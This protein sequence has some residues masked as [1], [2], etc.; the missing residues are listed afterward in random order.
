MQ[1]SYPGDNTFDLNDA[2]KILTIIAL[3]GILCAL[4]FSWT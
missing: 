4:V 3:V 1:C 2:H